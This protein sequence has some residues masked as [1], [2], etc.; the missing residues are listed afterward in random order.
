MRLKN[1][2]RLLR[3]QD[4]ISLVMA[5]GIL[6]V[7]T[8]SG[9]SL[10][11]YSNTN[12][13]SAEFS[14]DNSSAYDLAEAGINEMV[15]VLSKPE[16]NALKS[17]LLPS[18]SRTYDAGSVTWSG[19]LN[20]LTQTWS[21]T[22]TGRIK[23]PTG[24]TKDVT[25]VLTA[26]VPV[27]PSVA[28]PLNNP[29][30][31]YLFST[32]TGNTCDQQVNNNV[33]GSARFY[34]RGNMCLGNNAVINPSALIVH[35]NLDVSNNAAVG[36]NTSMSTRTET[37]VGGWCK[38][39]VGAV[40][41]GTGSCTGNQDARRIYSKI[42][43]AGSNPTT[44][45]VGVNSTAPVIATPAADF[46]TWYENAMPGPSQP[47]TTVSGAPPTFDTNYPA[48]DNN[49]GVMNLTPNA[50]Y[51]CRVGPAASTDSTTLAGA[52]TSSA[53]TLSVASATGFPTLGTFTIKVDNEYMLVTAGASTTTWTV[54]RA[55]QGTAAVAHS[56]GAPV[57]HLD[58][59]TGELSWNN[60]TKMLTVSGT[61][62]ID[63]SATISND[64]TNQ[65]NGQATIYLSGTFK[66]NGKLC[67]AVSGSNCDFAN[68]NPNTEML[69]F[70][71]NGSGGQ[72]AAGN[73]IE[74]ANNSSFEG[75]LYSSATVSFGE[76]AFSD[77]PIVGANIVLSNNVTT[78]PFANVVTVPVGM[79]GNPAVYAQPN[80]PQLYSG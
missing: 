63:G 20:D 77:G 61:I 17:D 44:Y 13:R 67:A 70:V 80:P 25:R 65:Y 50:S 52:I 57:T 73:G 48:K 4:G 54:T 64:A 47:C 7:L 55:Q 29:A 66:M 12:A 59:A 15:A 79:P 24:A 26:K 11:Y 32:R 49:V 53:T 34:V 14:Q 39:G 41:G 36:A 46:D 45:N 18:T 21:L 27:V 42:A 60:T 75:A 38:Y 33:G 43:V 58:P 30:W 6:G 2:I 68:W 10:V 28:Q 5:I 35:G 3:R 72:N 37:F 74:F 31:N 8:M 51:T 22:S 69:S 1:L 16:N 78:Q 56:A 62:F 71:T 40:S 9:T 19:T 76:N 23:N